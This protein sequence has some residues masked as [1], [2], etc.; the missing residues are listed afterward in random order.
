MNEKEKNDSKVKTNWLVG[1]IAMPSLPQWGIFL[2]GI[3]SSKNRIPVKNMPHRDKQEC[4]FC[5][6]PSTSLNDVS[7]S[8]VKKFCQGIFF[9]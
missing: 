5:Y 2:S 4:Q 8:V 6:F 1:M 3:Q 9:K 7:H